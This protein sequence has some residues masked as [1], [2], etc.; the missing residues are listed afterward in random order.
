MQDIF[1]LS[2]RSD[3]VSLY[4][5]ILSNAYSWVFLLRGGMGFH[6]IESAIGNPLTCGVEIH[7][8]TE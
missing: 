1:F 6:C 8:I 7:K 2:M 4:Q 3:H 5:G